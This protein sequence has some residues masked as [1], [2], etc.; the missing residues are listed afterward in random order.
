MG[1][2]SRLCIYLAFLAWCQSVLADTQ[3][4][5]TIAEG[6]RFSLEPAS[7]AERPEFDDS[8]WQTAHV[9]HNAQE[10]S[11]ELPRSTRRVWFRHRFDLPEIPSGH[12]VLLDVSDSPG[13]EA[14]LNGAFA[15]KSPA[16]QPWLH[17]DVTRLVR[18]GE[19]LL[20]LRCQVPGIQGRVRLFVQAPLDLEP[21]SLMIDTPGWEGGAARVRIRTTVENVSTQDQSYAVTASVLDPQGKLLAKAETGTRSVAAGAKGGLELMTETIAQP[22]VWS[23]EKPQLCRVVAELR[24]QGTTVRKLESN[25]GFRRFHFDADKGFFFNGNHLKLKGTVYYKIGPGKFADRG[26]LWKY[27]LGLIKGMGINFVR[28]AGGIDE[29]ILEEFDRAGILA[30]VD[31]HAD[32]DRARVRE[33]MRRD[34]QGRYNHPS[35][36]SWHFNGEGKDAAAGEVYSEAAKALRALDTTRPVFCVELGWRS[37][38]TVGLIDADIAG[39]GNYTGWYEGTLEHIGPYMDS[40]RALLRERY[41]RDM[42]IIVSNY[43]AASDSDVHAG[44]PRRNDFS[45]EYHTAFHRR[46]EQEIARRPW[47]AGGLIFAFRDSKSGQPIPRHTWKGVID[48][49]EMKKDAYYYYQS[50]WTTEPMVH[51]SEKSWT[52]RD[53]WPPGQPESIEVFSNCDVVELFHN[54]RSLGSR[55]KGERFS[56]EVQFREGLN[57]LKAAGERKGTKVQDTAELQIRQA[58]PQL[59]TRLVPRPD[60]GDLKLEW[61]SVK[62]VDRYNIHGSTSPDFIVSKENLLGTVPAPP[63]H[64]KPPRYGFYY[65][66]VALSGE[67]SG[68][69]SSSVG[70]AAGATEWRFANSGWLL[71]SP[72]VVDLDGD[73]QLEIVVGSYNGSLYAISRE[74]KELWRFDSG[75]TVISSP[76]VAPLVPGEKPSIVFNSDGI[77]Y[78]LSADGRLRWKRDGIRQF[79]RSA[80][81][82]ALGDLDGDGN[83]EIVAA[84]DTG[85]VFALEHTGRLRWR[86]ST[87]GPRTRGLSLTTPVLIRAEGQAT[88]VVFSADDGCTYL[89]DSQGKLRWKHDHRLGSS[90]P[91]LVPNTMTPAAGPLEEGGPVR[92][93]VGAGHLKALDLDGHLVWER[94]DVRGMPQISQLS[95]DR[96]RQIVVSDAATIHVVDGRGSDQWKFSLENSRDFFTQAPVSADLDGDGRP[97]LIAGTRAT[98]LCAISSAGKLLWKFQTDD[99]LSGSPAI[100]DLQ[101]DGYADVIFGSRDGY[102]YVVGGER[103]GPNA[104][105]SHQ[106]RGDPGRAAN[107]ARPS[108]PSPPR[109]QRR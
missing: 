7:G 22:P 98:Y 72:A 96:T 58:P 51:I 68:P 103:T 74:G 89:L 109:A 40:Y 57:S 55:R 32:A 84:S 83:L 29:T 73:R 85:E 36:I 70:W 20:V 43:G 76:A 97:D 30:T 47:V 41:G 33:N 75:G 107:Y 37:P 106:Y 108:N 42:P 104:A 26:S 16:G 53:S 27:E 61:E 31:V 39:Q 2:I 34:V 12:R 8:K 48:M 54:G 79:D 63:Y 14:W 81:S 94:K 64:T 13:L 102:L 56:W 17:L 87:A 49:K 9:P 46:F 101:G 67:K 50:I 24:V 1:R 66:V 11:D 44:N 80:K 69:P 52:P 5:I 86:F 45:H 92:I 10:I 59:E 21:D 25:F 77:L 23:L 18:R 62:G 35:L 28:T 93:V 99:E 3:A 19:N 91:G 90:T 78:V 105:V 4:S 82:P 38:G 65:K 60:T 88:A 15:S 71:S 6:W 100:A 95:G